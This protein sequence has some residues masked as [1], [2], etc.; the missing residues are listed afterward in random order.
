V[1]LVQQDYQQLVCDMRG[2]VG[3][4]KREWA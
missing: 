4:A 1:Q 3:S 2:S